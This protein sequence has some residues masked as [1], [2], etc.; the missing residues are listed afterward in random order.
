M[1]LPAFECCRVSYSCDPHGGSVGGGD[2]DIKFTT[3]TSPI[4][5]SSST[6]SASG[7][8]GLSRAMAAFIK[9][10]AKPGLIRSLA[11]TI[12][13][14]DFITRLILQIL[15]AHQDLIPSTISINQVI[16]LLGTSINIKSLTFNKPRINDVTV[17]SL[18]SPSLGVFDVAAGVSGT[19]PDAELHVSID[20]GADE[21][22]DF[23]SLV[24][25]VNASDTG[26]TL[27]CGDPSQ[28][29]QLGR[30]AING[31]HVTSTS[32]DPIVKLLTGVINANSA[33][34]NTIV[35][36][37]TNKVVPNHFPLPS[38]LASIISIVCSVLPS[39]AARAR[40]PRLLALASPRAAGVNLDPT[41]FLKQVVNS[42]ISGN[43][44][45]DLGNCR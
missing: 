19:F 1:L 7:G 22:V 15:Q 16:S 29:V 38:N 28:D 39:E 26:L 36:A 41:S 25:F 13:P 4:G 14:T 3:A 21:A 34:L 2:S 6:R 43:P 5:T 42:I 45:I 10:Q 12:S 8:A 32:S 33:I 24:L 27:P 37:L 20:S 11:A 18:N 30:L 17:Y 23:G 31:I 44:V 35:S 9:A 40:G